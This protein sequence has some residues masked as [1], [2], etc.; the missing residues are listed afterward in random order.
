MSV[1][2]LFDNQCIIQLYHELF[3]PSIIPIGEVYKLFEQHQ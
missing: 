3:A 1:S 2:F